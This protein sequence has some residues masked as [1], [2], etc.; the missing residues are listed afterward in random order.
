MVDKLLTPLR[1]LKHVN[2]QKRRLRE[3]WLE[4]SAKGTGFQILVNSPE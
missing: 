3:I 4:P 1:Y 2:V